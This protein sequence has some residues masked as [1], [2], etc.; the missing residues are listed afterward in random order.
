MTS[1]ERSIELLKFLRDNGYGLEDLISLLEQLSSKKSPHS[2]LEVRVAN[3]LQSLAV[4]PNI[5][6]YYYLKTA[7]IL[8]YK[9][10]ELKQKITSYLYPMVAEKH[11]TT[12]A[13][14]ERGIRHAIEVSF[15]RMD[16]DT[17]NMYFAN[18]FSNRRGKA[19][20][21]E[22]ITTLVEILKMEE[23]EAAE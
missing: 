4:P 14:A 10:P 23:I 5:C 7:V 13:R 17:M 21:S 8:V 22:F 20:N 19:T 12:P 1:Q 2:P 9:Q 3:H 11:Q 16:M 15:D 18:T 6:G